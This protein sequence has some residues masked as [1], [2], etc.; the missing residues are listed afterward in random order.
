MATTIL[1]R[2]T[3]LGDF[4]VGKSALFQRYM[5]DHIDYHPTI[6]VDFR[7][8][9][10]MLRGIDVRLQLWDTAGQERFRSITQ[11]YVRNVFV[12]F[13]VFDVTRRDSYDHLAEWVTFVNTHNGDEPVCVL[14]ANKIDKP[15]TEWE[16]QPAEIDAFAKAHD[17]FG[18]HYVSTCP[19]REETVSPS[20]PVSPSPVYKMFSRTLEQILD[21][22]GVTERTPFYTIEQN[23]QQ[24]D[25]RITVCVGAHPGTNGM[26][27]D[28]DIGDIGEVRSDGLRTPPRSPTSA[29]TKMSRIAMTHFRRTSST[30]PPTLRPTHRI[31]K[32][33]ERCHDWWGDVLVQLKGGRTNGQETCGC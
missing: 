24:P 17:L 21:H 12:C 27:D 7:S 1:I 30:S 4:A 11:A 15:I 2:A 10:H 6:G 13:L 20:S 32:Y 3:L 25:R 16:V 29:A 19:K 5:H 22:Y 9:S 28:D 33:T 26:D 14:V 18:V 31:H 8:K 23:L